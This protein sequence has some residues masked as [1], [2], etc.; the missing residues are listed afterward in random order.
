[1]E[2]VII[3]VVVFLI[4]MFFVAILTQA[5]SGEKRRKDMYEAHERDRQARDLQ[6]QAKMGKSL[7]RQRATITGQTV[8]RVAPLLTQ[9]PFNPRDAVHVNFGIDY[10]VFEGYSEEDVTQI[11]FVEV[12]T[13]HSDLSKRQRQIR[14]AIRQ[15]RVK[16]YVFSVDLDE[17]LEHT[18]KGGV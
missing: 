17:D 7:R 13:G 10:L 11:T 18:L 4:V 15:G 2:W 1:M 5:S 3:I 6:Y 9:W 12:K 8:E 14:N 16:Y